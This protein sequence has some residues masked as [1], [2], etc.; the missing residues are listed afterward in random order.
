VRAGVDPDLDAITRVARRQSV[1]QVLRGL[2]RDGRRARAM[3]G[4]AIATSHSRRFAEIFAVLG[5]AVVLSA[6]AVIHAGIS[7]DP[8][9]HIGG[10]GACPQCQ[11]QQHC[12]KDDEGTRAEKAVHAPPV[13]ESI[14]Q[15]VRI[16]AGKRAIRL[17]A[18]EK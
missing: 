11:L 17:E 13:H 5:V 8:D 15:I 18:G 9:A 10:V 16:Y 2:V 3:V 6:G 7:I 4:S 1:D 12:R 14:R